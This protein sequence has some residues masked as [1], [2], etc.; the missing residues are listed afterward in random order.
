MQFK[1][2]LQQ[3]TPRCLLYE[4]VVSLL[5]E[6]VVSLLYEG[7]VSLLYEGVVSDTAD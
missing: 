2:L 7:V 3:T 6:G 5:N 1:A 4:G